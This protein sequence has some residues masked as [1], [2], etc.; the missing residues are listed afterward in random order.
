MDSFLPVSWFFSFPSPTHDPSGN[1][2]THMI[3][4][5]IDI[6]KIIIVFVI[7]GL[8][9]LGLLIASIYALFFYPAPMG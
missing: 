2:V 7:P 6:I 3:N 5:F 9:A 1:Q 4:R 8:F